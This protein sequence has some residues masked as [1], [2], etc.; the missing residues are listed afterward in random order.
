MADKTD[1]YQEAFELVKKALLI[2]PNDPAFIDSMGWVYYR[3]NNLEKAILYLSKA[4]SLVK[5]DEI[6]AHLG[7]ALWMAGR[8]SEALEV[9][10]NGLEIEPS[11]PYLSKVKEKFQKE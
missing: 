4:L 8:K 3:L 1:R 2:R 9:W 11:S 6:A 7:E 10:E 5:D